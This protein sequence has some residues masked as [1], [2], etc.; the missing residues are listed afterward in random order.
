MFVGVFEIRGEPIDHDMTQFFSFGL[1]L[2]K[3]Q[4]EELLTRPRILL[5]FNRRRSF[6]L[7]GRLHR[8]WIGCEKILSFQTLPLP[9]P[10]FSH[11]PSLFVLLP[12]LSLT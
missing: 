2:S 1:D 8:K 3:W 12:S 6:C 4:M 5:I 11:F 9:Q 10:F 7:G